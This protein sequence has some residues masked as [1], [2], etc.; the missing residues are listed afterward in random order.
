MIAGGSCAREVRHG[1]T[2]LLRCVCLA[3]AC[4]M[5]C[6]LGGCAKDEAPSASTSNEATGAAFVMPSEVSVPQVADSG[7]VTTIDTSGVAQGWVGARAFSNSRL[8]FQVNC[9]EMTYNYDLP[10]DG[11][12]TLFPLNMGNGSYG[13]RIM[14]NIEGNSYAELDSAYA[15]V[16]LSSEFAPFLVPNV[17][18]A[19][20][21]D[22]A[23][24]AQ[25]GKLMENVQNQGEAVREICTFVANNVSYDYDKAAQLSQSTGYMP[26]ADATLSSG[27]GICL[28][29][30][31]LTAAMMRSVGLPAQVVT[32]YVSPDNLYH[33]WTMVY[34][35]GRWQTAQFSI[36]PNTWSRCDVTLAS[37][38][39]GST[40]GDG[41]SYID[42]Y[43]Y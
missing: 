17:Y 32:G 42:K 9:G 19:Y 43:V 14:A 12:P 20:R 5:I 39:T 34:V 15:D 36:S 38:G 3:L 31:C 10:S 33:A 25:A 29:Y 1:A 35:D 41:T 16:T 28:D 6:T 8:K 27:T 13:F 18:C 22:S 21:Q 23:C 30:A 26:N 7:A 24:V 4:L 37:A 2:P 11:S 40:T